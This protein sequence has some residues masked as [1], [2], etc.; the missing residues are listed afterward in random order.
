MWNKWEQNAA[1]KAEEEKRKANAAV[2]I[3]VAER[4]RQAKKNTMNL[5][6]I[7]LRLNTQY[8]HLG[9]NIL[10]QMDKNFKILNGIKKRGTV[11]VNTINNYIERVK[12]ELESR[13][14]AKSIAPSAIAKAVAEAPGE[15]NSGVRTTL[16]RSKSSPAGLSQLPPAAR[17]P[18]APARAEAAAQEQKTP[19][20]PETQ[21]GNTGSNPILKKIIQEGGNYRKGLNLSRVTPEEALKYYRELNQFSYN[22]S[23]NTY[24]QVSLRNKFMKKY[25]EDLYTKIKPNNDEIEAYARAYIKNSKNPNRSKR[26]AVKSLKTKLPKLYLGQA[27]VKRIGKNDQGFFYKENPEQKTRNI[28]T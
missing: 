9:N 6:E 1:A 19:P 4:G 15:T 10:E 13:L 7:T 23:N 17:A 12:K 27:K 11:S 16:Q 3:Q 24:K 18:A 28:S 8:K 25:G 22:S 2:K 5:R 26:E 21:R 20:K 14:A